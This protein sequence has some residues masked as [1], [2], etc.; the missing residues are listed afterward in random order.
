[1]K[2]SAVVVLLVSF[3]SVAHAFVPPTTHPRIAAS[4]AI[5][6]FYLVFRNTIVDFNIYWQPLVEDM[7][8]NDAR[9]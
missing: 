1:M 8:K 9:N 4:L 2:T 3:V 7:T 5:V 6:V